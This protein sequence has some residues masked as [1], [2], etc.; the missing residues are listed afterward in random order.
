[1]SSVRDDRKLGA[2]NGGVQLLCEVYWTAT[3]HGAPQQQ[4]GHLNPREEVSGMRGPASSNG[5]RASNQSVA[6]APHHTTPSHGKTG[7]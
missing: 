3:I 5:R 1:M 4:H 7:A 2:G 6:A